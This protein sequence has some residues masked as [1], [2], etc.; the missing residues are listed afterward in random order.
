LSKVVF[1]KVCTALLNL[2]LRMQ[3]KVEV[4]KDWMDRAKEL[5]AM[6]ENSHE[7]DMRKNLEIQHGVG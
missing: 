7:A 4:G 6:E 3:H 2:H 5:G 1:N